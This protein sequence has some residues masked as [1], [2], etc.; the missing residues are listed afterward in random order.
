MLMKKLFIL[1]AATVLLAACEKDD[2]AVAERFWSDTEMSTGA[3]SYGAKITKLYSVVMRREL[4]FPFKA[5]VMELNGQRYFYMMRSRFNADL[6]VG[7]YISFQTF[8]F[9]PSE[10]SAINGYDLGDGTNAVHNDETSAGNYLV[11]SNPIEATVKNMFAMKIR[12]TIAFWPI[13]T[14]FIE[15]TAGNLIYIK[16]SKLNIDLKPGDGIVYN[17]YTLFPNE[18]LALKKL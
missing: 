17:V 18:V 1:V 9:C 13:D 8:S 16:K 15:T 10:I 14:W 12:Y 3:D 2:S 11:A 7:D 4:P 6:H 5:Y